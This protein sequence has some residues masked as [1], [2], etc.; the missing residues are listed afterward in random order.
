MTNY[1]AALVSH[2]D[3]ERG[4]RAIAWAVAHLQPGELPLLWIGRKADLENEKLFV[5]FSK[6]YPVMTERD[7]SAAWAGGPVIAA[8]PSAD[9]LADLVAM[10]RMTALVV[11][12]WNPSDVAAWAAT[13]KPE[14]LTPGGAPPPAPPTVHPVVAA[15]LRS[16]THPVDPAQS[17]GGTFEHRDVI[18]AIK[19]LR[20]AGY[21]MEPE[22][23]FAWA[24]RHGWSGAGAKRLREAVTKANNGVNI[25]AR[26]HDT[27]PYPPALAHWREQAGGA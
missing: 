17:M 22:A 10:P 16:C 3:P 9:K 25:Q 5:A 6:R 14:L 19:T 12:E 20:T 18:R 15:A 13:A 26:G 27:T 8:W 2:P 1:P 21:A 23:M 11:L 24:V 7:R 4:R